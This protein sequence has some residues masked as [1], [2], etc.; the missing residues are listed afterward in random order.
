M[1]RA[2]VPPGSAAIGAAPAPSWCGLGQAGRGPS[3]RLQIRD[4][5]TDI[6]RIRL[7]GRE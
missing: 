3:R 4:E 1:T 7:S 2:R 6:A 5:R